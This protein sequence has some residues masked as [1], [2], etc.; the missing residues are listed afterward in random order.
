MIEY[1]GV[2]YKCRRLILL[3][4]LIYIGSVSADSLP[5][6]QLNLPAGFRIAVFAKVENPRQLAISQSGVIFAGSRKAGK[7]HGLIDQDGDAYAETVLVLAEDLTMPSGLAIRGNDLYIAALSDVLKISNIDQ[8][9]NQLKDPEIIYRGFP[10]KRHHGWKFI[11]FGPDGLLYVPVGAPCNICLSDN[12]VFASIQTLDVTAQP[13]IPQTFAS[14]VRNSVGFTWHPETGHLWFT[15]NGRDL[16]GDDRPPCELNE[17]SQRGQHFG[18][19][20][21]HGSSIADPKFGKK[22]GKLQTT[23]PILELGPHVAPLG[24][25]FY[26]GDQFPADYRQQLFIAEHGSWN[27]STSVG[28]TGYRISIARQTS[29]GLKYDTFIDGWLQ[30]NKAWGRP[31]DILELADG[32]LLISDDKANVIYRVSYSGDDIHNGPPG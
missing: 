7:V 25:A 13:M 1:G 18:Y 23:A 8:R 10:N 21:I 11:D 24:I 14:G 28:H 32:S 15:D 9:L 22:L 30:D 16:L 29:R 31:A 17:A 12:P 4:V 19:P 6:H 5:L 2:I 26:E 20:F 3:S 27:R